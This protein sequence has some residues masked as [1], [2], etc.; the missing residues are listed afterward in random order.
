MKTHYFWK[1]GQAIPGSA[2]PTRKTVGPR[3]TSSCTTSGDL[4]GISSPN[5]A[6]AEDE[7]LVRQWRLLVVPGFPLPKKKLRPFFVDVVKK[8]VPQFFVASN[9]IQINKIWKQ[10]NKDVLQV[11]DVLELIMEDIG[12]FWWENP[13]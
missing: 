8:M 7:K 4:G 5:L 12:L 6:A 9:F 11:L 10:W 13:W 3:P 1:H 2:R